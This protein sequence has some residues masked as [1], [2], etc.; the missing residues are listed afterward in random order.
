MPKVENWNHKNTLTD[1]LTAACDALNIVFDLLY[2]TSGS[3][4]KLSDKVVCVP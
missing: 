1:I 2:S 4:S 3:V